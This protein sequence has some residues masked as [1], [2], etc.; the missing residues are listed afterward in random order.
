MAFVIRTRVAPEDIIAGVRRAVAQVDPEQPLA[1]IRTM[2]EI[3][4]ETTLSRRFETWLLLS[5]ALTAVFLSALG[6][7]GVLSMSVTQRTREFGI[8]MA[9][10]ATARSVSKLVFGEAFRL[11]AFG[12]A[13]GILLVIWASR[14]LRNLLYG[15]KETDA[16]LYAVAILVLAL[17]GL[18]A[19]W[20]PARRASCAD[21]AVVLREE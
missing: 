6:V 19:C 15:V 18:A 7:F 12:A 16:R 8:R 4:E 5:F 10:G 2:R 11:L 14:L 20:I 13:A 21:P 3:M 9:L 1:H 17:A